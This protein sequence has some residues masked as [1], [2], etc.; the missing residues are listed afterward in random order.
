LI[1]E[2]G[3]A[4][5][6]L[7][8]RHVLDQHSLDKK[9]GRFRILYHTLADELIRIRVLSLRWCLLQ[10]S[11][12]FRDELLLLRRHGGSSSLAVDTDVL[13]YGAGNSPDQAT[14]ITRDFLG[15]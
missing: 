6:G 9:I 2:L 10:A 15:A 1:L 12:E 14:G 4:V 7:A 11:K 5:L 8:E 13:L 3:D